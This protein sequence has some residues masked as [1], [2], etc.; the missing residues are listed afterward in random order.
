MFESNIGGTM[1]THMNIRGNTGHVGIGTTSPSAK[2]H[3]HSGNVVVTSGKQLISTNTYS[4]APVGM[5]TIQGPTNGGTTINSD[6]WGLVIGPQHTRSSTANTYYAG[7]AFNHLLNHGGSAT[8]NNAP[9]AWIGTRLHDTPGSERGFLV[10]ATKSG[11]GTTSSDVPIERMCIDPVDGLVGIGSTDPLSRFN[12]KGSQGNWR[13]D[14]DDVSNEIQVL[15]TTPANDGF[16]TYRL[17]TNET[18]FDTGGSERLKIDSTGNITHV[19]SSPEYHFAL[20]ELGIAT[21]E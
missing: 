5:L 8:Y 4:Q 1:T 13:V 2:L 11:T 15:A 21:G 7:I 19:S 14:T 10:F 20:L 3:V 12:V 17:R 9:Q 18:I 6:V 16:R